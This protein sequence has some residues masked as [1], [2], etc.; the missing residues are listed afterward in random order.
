MKTV[1]IIID[2]YSSFFFHKNMELYK[3]GRCC[4]FDS[5]RY[6]SSDVGNWIDG[7]NLVASY[8]MFGGVSEKAKKILGFTGAYSMN[9]FLMHTFVRGYYF[10]AFSYS[11]KYPIIILAVLVIDTLLFSVCL[12]W[13]KNVSGYNKAVS[14]ICSRC[15]H[16]KG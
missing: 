12:E 14:I 1:A 7:I 6:C 11:F 16:G 4:M 13:M 9:M 8:N 15:L 5:I 3:K 10:K 2:V